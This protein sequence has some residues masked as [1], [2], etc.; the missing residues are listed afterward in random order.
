M[1]PVTRRH[2]NFT[3]PRSEPTY[4]RPEEAAEGASLVEHHA[5]LKAYFV[6]QTRSA[7]D[8]DDYVHEVFSRVLASA[9]LAHPVENWRGMLLRVAKSVVIDQFRRDAV[10]QRDRHL[11][12]D[13]D[14]GALADS[15]PDPEAAA[16]H[17]QRLAAA[18]KILAGLDPV[19][20]QAFLLARVE[21]FGHK[22]VA[23][24]LGISQRMVARHVQQALYVLARQEGNDGAS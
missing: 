19:C 2:E 21:G 10:R 12:L 1:P 6:R 20:R 7:Q 4:S 5:F 24:R 17:R 11:P 8:A 3:P 22:E 23:K 14:L 15:Q 13:E 16:S 18:E 9:G